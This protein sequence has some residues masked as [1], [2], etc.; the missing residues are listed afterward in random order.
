MLHNLNLEEKVTEAR[1]AGVWEKVMGE[2]IARYTS[3]IAYRNKSLS[4]KLSSPVLRQELSYEKSKIIGLINEALG[5]N[6][7]EEITFN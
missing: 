5:Q 7:V 2:G 1:I 4:I 3:S 6:S